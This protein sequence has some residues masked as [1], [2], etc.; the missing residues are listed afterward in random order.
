MSAC[1]HPGSGHFATVVLNLSSPPNSY[2]SRNEYS[3]SKE[4]KNFLYDFIFGTSLPFIQFALLFRSS[5]KG[6]L[7]VMIKR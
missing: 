7:P 6:S 4:M 3:Y 1:Q 2:S 5:K